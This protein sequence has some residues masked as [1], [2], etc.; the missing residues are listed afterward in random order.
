M[1]FRRKLKIVLSGPELVEVKPL[2]K[3]MTLGSSWSSSIFTDLLHT[4]KQVDTITKGRPKQL[5][6]RGMKITFEPS[7]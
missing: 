7:K 1:D 6:C 4:R 3:W 2:N 5:D